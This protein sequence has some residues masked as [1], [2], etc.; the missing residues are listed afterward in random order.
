[1]IRVAHGEAAMEAIR[2]AWGDPV[3]DL[4]EAGDDDE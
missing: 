4:Q 2:Q 3:W 1:M